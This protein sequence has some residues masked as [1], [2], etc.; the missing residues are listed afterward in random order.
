[1]SKNT[2]KIVHFILQNM[3]HV[4][5]SLLK[6]KSKRKKTIVHFNVV[7]QKLRYTLFF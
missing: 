1:M 4:T 3:K 2:L 7:S 5:P 6:K